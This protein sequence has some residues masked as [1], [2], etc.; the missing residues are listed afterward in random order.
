MEQRLPGKHEVVSS[1]LGTKKILF[2]MIFTL[3]HI[4]NSLLLTKETKKIETAQVGIT[5]LYPV[6]Y[7]PLYFGKII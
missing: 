4:N 1:I 7:S 5:I 6:I 2:Y 3:Y